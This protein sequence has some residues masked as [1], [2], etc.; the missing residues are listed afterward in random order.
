MNVVAGDRNGRIGMDL[1]F[2]LVL[3]NIQF[4]DEGFYTCKATNVLGEASN[5]TQLNVM[6]I[7]IRLF[8][9]FLSNIAY[10]IFYICFIETF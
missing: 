3:T 8:V 7:Q 6:G 5:S 2:G 10:L 1:A 9:Y 4:S